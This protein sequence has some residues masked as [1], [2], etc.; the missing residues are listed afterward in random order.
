MSEDEFQNLKELLDANAVLKQK[1]DAM[2]KQKNQLSSAVR[3][4]KPTLPGQAKAVTK[5][6]ANVRSKIDPDNIT[7]QLKT[8]E[9]LKKLRREEFELKDCSFRPHINVKSAEIVQSN[10]YIPIYDRPAPEKKPA[11]STRELVESELFE[12]E[13]SKPKKKADP[14]FYKRQL[15]WQRKMEEKQQ[16]ERLQKQLSEHS[17]LYQA[18]RTNKEANERMGGETSDFMERLRIQEERAKQRRLDLE[19]KYNDCTFKPKINVKSQNV[20]SRVFQARQMEHD[21][22]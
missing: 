16:N 8:Q 19:S 1:L 22:D 3:T 18:P 10:V 14:D 5:Q 12:P 13:P 17:E 11:E 21:E 4:S 9:E 2:T 20:N 15:E 6:Y 7:V